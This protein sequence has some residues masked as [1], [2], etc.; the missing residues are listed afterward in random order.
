MGQEDTWKMKTEIVYLKVPVRIR[1]DSR[2]LRAVAILSAKASLTVDLAGG[3]EKGWY[4]A[5]AG[6]SKRTRVTRL[7]CVKSKEAIPGK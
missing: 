1:Y 6:L 4:S 5:F 2:K 7:R 3:S